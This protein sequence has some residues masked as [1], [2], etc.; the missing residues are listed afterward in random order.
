MEFPVKIGGFYALKIEGI[1]EELISTTKIE[2]I[3]G[4]GTRDI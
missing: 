3:Y 2:I 1:P 4:K